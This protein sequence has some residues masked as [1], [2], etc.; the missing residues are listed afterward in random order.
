MFDNGT[1]EFCS[2]KCAIGIV[3]E[4]GLVLERE[5]ERE[6]VCVGGGGAGRCG[7]CGRDF[8]TFF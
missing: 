8:L 3:H 2:K 5:R 4:C 1:G 6:S 7:R